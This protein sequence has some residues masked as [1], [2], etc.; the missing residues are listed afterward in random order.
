MQVAEEK[1][2]TRLSTRHANRVLG[3]TR[4][5]RER[6]AAGL[7]FVSPWL[8]GFSL[9][10]LYPIVSSLYYSLCEFSV[11]QPPQFV[12]LANYTDLLADDVFRLA[13][14]NTVFYAAFALPLGILLALALAMLLNTGVRGMAF[15]RT[16]FFLPS[17]LPTVALAILWM[18]IFNGQYGILNFVLGKLGV[19]GPGWLSDPHWSKPALIVLSLWGVGH[20]VVIYLAGLQDVPVHLYEAA[21]LD[22]ANWLQKIRHVTIPTVSPVILFNLIMGIIGTFQYFAVPYIM[23]P[24]GT[25][26][27]SAYFLAVNLYDNAFT[28]LRMGYASAMA[29]VLFSI[30]L[31]LTLIALRL[32]SR[33]VHYGG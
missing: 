2:S 12:G 13:L 4:G 22:G 6:L 14:R 8:V 32:S 26:A 1:L 28:Y 20:A 16:I 11:L 19:T 31:V 17:L 15:Y 25:P 5:E 21:D 29:W 23:T 24:N 18:W 3:L 27:R 9:F 7:M 10:M 30:V 33:H